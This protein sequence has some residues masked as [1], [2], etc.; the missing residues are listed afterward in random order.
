MTVK[1]TLNKFKIF[2]YCAV[3]LGCA[4]YGNAAN[5]Q[6]YIPATQIYKY[7]KEQNTTALRY[8]GYAID[9]QDSNGN[10]AL[11]MALADGNKQAYHT[12]L[13]Y[14]ANPNARCATYLNSQ[15]NFAGSTA[16]SSGSSVLGLSPTGW[17]IAA[18][19][20]GGGVAIASSGGGGGG[21]G[22]SSPCAGYQKECPA[23]Y[24]PTEDTCTSGNT[25]YYQCKA[26]TCEGYVETCAAGYHMTGEQCH[27]GDKTM[28][29]C[30]VNQCEGFVERCPTGYEWSGKTC[31]SGETKY[32]LEC[33]EAKC[34]GYNFSSKPENCLTEKT[35]RSG[36]KTKHK[37]EVCKNGW[38][39]DDCSTPTDCGEDFKTECAEGE[40]IGSETCTSGG[41]D[42][43][44]CKTRSNT[45]KCTQYNPYADKCT[46]CED[47]FIPDNNGYCV[48]KASVCVSEGYL[49]NPNC[50]ETTQIITECPYD[51][52]YLKCECRADYVPA[53][54]G[55]CVTKSQACENDEY[56][57][58]CANY[59]TQYLDQTQTCQYDSSYHKCVNR[60]YINENCTAYVETEDKCAACE[61]G[62]QVNAEGKCEPTD[63]QRCL[64]DGFAPGETV[65]NYDTY[66][67]AICRYDATYHKCEPRTKSTI[68]C[69]VVS[70]IS[71]ECDECEHLVGGHTEYVLTDGECILTNCIGFSENITECNYKTEYLLTCEENAALHYCEARHSI[72]PDC[73]EY[74]SNT[75][76]S[77]I[78]KTCEEGAEPS[79]DGHSCIFNLCS[80]QG[81]TK[82]DIT[83]ENTQYQENCET[84]ASYHRC[85]ARENT[86]ENCAEYNDE[87]IDNGVC[88]ECEPDYD[89][90]NN[91]CVVRQTCTEK[92]YK[93]ECDN[94][95]EYRDTGDTCTNDGD[96]QT[97]YKCIGRTYTDDNCAAYE[98][99]AD[100]CAA[101]D[102]G[103]Q[104]NT[105]GRCELTDSQR[106]INDNYT[107]GCANYDTQYLD[108]TQTCQYDSS[109]HK[110]IG[111]TYTDDN[112]TAYETDADKCAACD[113]GYQVNTEGKCEPICEGYIQD[114]VVCDDSEEYIKICPENVSYRKCEPRT[115]KVENCIR[116][117]NKSSDIGRCQTCASDYTLINSQNICSYNAP[118]Y[119]NS[120]D[121]SKCSGMGG[122]KKGETS[123]SYCTSCIAGYHIENG[124]CVQDED[125]TVWTNN[126]AISYSGSS[127][128]KIY[129]M[130]GDQYTKLIN[131]AS[132]TITITGANVNVYGM[133]AGSE[134]KAQTAQN[135][136]KIELADNTTPTTSGTDPNA[137]FGMYGNNPNTSL[138]NGYRPEESGDNTLPV[139]EISGTKGNAYGMYG[140]EMTNYATIRMTDNGKPKQDG[141]TTLYNTIGM[142]AKVT[143]TTYIYQNAGKIEISKSV[144]KT[145]GMYAHS[146]VT[147]TFINGVENGDN[148]N[149]SIV[150]TENEN[151]TGILGANII[152]YAKIEIKTSNGPKGIEARNT[153]SNLGTINISDSITSVTYDRIS[154]IYS[155]T[156][157][158]TLTNGSENGNNSGVSI[159][160]SNNTGTQND[161]SEIVGMYGRTTTNYA[162][163]YLTGN[164]AASGM[165]AS[166]SIPQA[167]N[168]S[169]G[170]ITVTKNK[171]T[172]TGM[173]GGQG[174]T[175]TNSGQI[176][177][178]ENLAATY[179]MWGRFGGSSLTNKGNITVQ[180]NANSAYGMYSNSGAE[181]VLLIN[182][183][184]NENGNNSNVKITVTGNK[185][186]TYGMCGNDI[187]NYAYITVS[188]TESGQ[189]IYGIFAYN[190]TEDY[191]SPVLNAGTIN[192]TAGSGAT[193]YGI[194]AAGPNVNII[195]TGKIIMNGTSCTGTDCS[196][197]NNAIVL[198]GATLTTQ[199][200]MSAPVLNLSS[201]GGT[202]MATASAK[203]EVENEMSGDLVM[204]S[205]VVTNGFEDTYTVAD[206]IDAGDVSGLNL[207]SQSALFDAELQN[208]SDAVLTMKSFDDVVENASI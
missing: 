197:T 156:N 19:L 196:G 90:T 185:S 164:T 92:G 152:N 11:C 7:A 33:V 87:H 34:E 12:L 146:Q 120:T 183:Y 13:K 114:D 191:P 200:L 10:T 204:S 131:G 73:I 130:K 54:N 180:N 67:L 70:Q 66:Y 81:Y 103:Y 182:G 124:L 167:I 51:D 85:S 94:K 158:S 83:C 79:E 21:S 123:G 46:A 78:C 145:Y 30:A 162:T 115:N 206:M 181:K 174:A 149:I 186:R 190:G 136:G 29:K 195:N 142:G 192:V 76:E 104:V 42:Y 26:D 132:G 91:V 168:A 99:N 98:T 111:R 56:V 201:V 101:C 53:D 159:T 134:T 62:Y 59:D 148:S 60:T 18:A 102:D 97:Y 125:D 119:I 151:S 163:V 133:Y 155:G 52:N 49:H 144:K 175:L 153:A 64:N 105:E 157:N 17:L 205:D 150:L 24:V 161:V 169:N 160:L 6:Q 137:V 37:C 28:Y 38:Q 25:T 50:N 16:Y 31:Q 100:K 84:D 57:I 184:E 55:T 198:N 177:M 170:I 189:E 128:E 194:Y 166:G 139:I 8:A 3:L 127:T 61:E 88:K 77:S 22:G 113:D 45:D 23:G 71:D 39:G 110:C 106:C 165:Y 5:A 173:S 32:L 178:T 75:S 74:A 72:I 203:F 96:T 112:C 41:V 179:G 129:G 176:V 35:C 147:N 122:C 47:G 187:K 15:K 40:Y 116:Y 118:C 193:G 199:S 171:S 117:Q 207:L 109:Y 43:K 89:L 69:A 172:A 9:A 154:G 108:L 68:G 14:G 138:I 121:F 202:V 1:L 126:D 4:I 36:D 141:D 93:T 86:V 58:S 65:C 80:I 27:S 44:Q 63:S 188:G 2:L 95:D 135:K 208:E 140:S 20:V 143:G 107:Q 48:T 82:D